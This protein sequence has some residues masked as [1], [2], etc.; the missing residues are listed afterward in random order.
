MNITCNYLN[1]TIHSIHSHT[2]RH[3]AK[4]NFYSRLY[5]T[6][7]HLGLRDSLYKP[8]LAGPFPGHEAQT[9]HRGS[10]NCRVGKLPTNHRKC[11]SALIQRVLAQYPDRAVAVAQPGLIGGSSFP[12]SG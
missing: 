5:P 7:Y 3:F 9:K 4:I 10:G 8:D 6:D 1:S 11:P 12:Q 2:Y